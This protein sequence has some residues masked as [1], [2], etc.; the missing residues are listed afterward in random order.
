MDIGSH[1]INLFLHLFGE[2]MEV[3]AF[4][5]SP[6]IHD[7][8]EQ[9]ALV[10]MRFAGG[11]VGTLE[12]HF[13]RPDPDEFTILGSAGRLEVRPLNKGELL[14]ETDEGRRIE[15]HP[16]CDNFNAPLVADFVAAILENRAPLVTGREGR[17]TNQVMERAYQDAIRRGT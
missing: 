4:T 17:A 5:A 2:A 3:K 7:Q 13:G 12:C 6:D 11:V 16:P 10:M 15:K 8:A 1:R 14:I 9:T